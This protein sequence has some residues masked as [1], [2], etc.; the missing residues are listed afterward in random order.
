MSGLEHYD[1]ELASLDSEIHRYALICGVDLANHYEVEACLNRPH[2]DW[3]DDK[4]RESLQ[5]LLMLRI[6]VETEMLEEGLTP[7][8][9]ISP[10]PSVEA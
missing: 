7:S 10:S 4:A 5:G 3:A 2:A 6:K 9:L 8:P 1:R